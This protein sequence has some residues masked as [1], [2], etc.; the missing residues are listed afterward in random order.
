MAGQS[1]ALLPSLCLGGQEQMQLDRWMLQQVSNGA[2]PNGPQALL[3][4]Y[5]WSSAT[6]SLG[7]HQAPPAGK[8]SSALPWVRRP[9]GGATVLHGGDLCYA[10]ALAA[11]PRGRRQ[12]Y[13]D[14]N[15]WLQSS[16]QLLGQQL[17]SGNEP[18]RRQLPHCFASATAADLVDR[19][20]SKRIGS[21]QLWR[22]GRLLQHGSIQLN[23][24]QQL[25]RQLF[26]DAAPTPLDAGSAERLE[27]LLITQAQGWLFAR[28]P[29][30]WAW[31]EPWP[32]AALTSGSAAT[33]SAIGA[34]ER[35]RG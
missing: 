17:C 32:W 29:L 6:L 16:F 14:L 34:S 30:Q 7:H 5:R 13:G 26:A 27:S 19:G 9:S 31:P 23:P 1:W 15:Q 8:T 4:F 25:W 22:Q 20:G 3:R 35:P 24:D 11:P 28:A 10:I 12:A 21:A 18:Q 33:V 2:N